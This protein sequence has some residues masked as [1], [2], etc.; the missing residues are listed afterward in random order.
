[1]S[2]K[3]VDERKEYKKNRKENIKKEERRE[4]LSRASIWIVAAI[5]VI[6]V[7]IAGGV[8]I[9]NRNKAAADALPTYSSTSFVLG[10]LAGI[11]D[12]EAAEID[13]KEEAE[14][15]A[16]EAATEEAASEEAEEETEKASAEE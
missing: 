7:G 3:K 13:E 16:E 4:K 9:H 11:Q 6:G 8:S 1:M 14:T 2:Q 12:A 15:A 10:D 5:F